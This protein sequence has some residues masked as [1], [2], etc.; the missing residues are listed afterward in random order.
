MDPNKIVFR[1]NAHCVT[2]GRTCEFEMKGKLCVMGPPC[3]LFSRLIGSILIMFKVYM[4]FPL[5][6]FQVYYPTPP[7]SETQAGET[8]KVPEHPEGS[9]PCGCNGGPRKIIWER[10]WKCQR[11]WFLTDGESIDPWDWQGGV[12]QLQKLKVSKKMK[13]CCSPNPTL[14]LQFHCPVLRLCPQMF[15]SPSARPREYRLTWSKDYTWIMDPWTISINSGQFSFMNGFDF[16]QFQHWFLRMRWTWR[17]WHRTFSPTQRPIPT[18]QLIALPWSHM[19]KSQ[20]HWGESLCFP[21]TWS[22]SEFNILCW[23]VFNSTVN[24]LFFF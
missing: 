20:S 5:L 23:I 18:W 13:T 15:G 21:G 4:F 14:S 9:G 7:S 3:V 12:S 22:Q 16:Q 17:F 10:A 11:L 8:G 6:L 2:H 1:K 19:K 24:T